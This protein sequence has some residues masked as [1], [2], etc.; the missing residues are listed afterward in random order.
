[1]SRLRPFTWLMPYDVYER[2]KVVSS[3]LQ[4]VLPLKESPFILDVG[5]RIDLLEQ[6]LP[7]RVLS[8]NPDGTGAVYASGTALPFADDSFTAVVNIDTL[9]HLPPDIRLP[10]V[11]ECLRVARRYIIIAAPY[12]SPKH[13]QHEKNLHTLYKNTHGHPHKYLSEHIRYELPSPTWLKELET[14]VVPASVQHFYAGDFIWQGKTF[15]QSIKAAQSPLLQA[16][17]I[18]LKNRITSLA[19]L[20]PIHLTRT[21]TETTNRFYLLVQKQYDIKPG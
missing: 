5:G 21:P 16:K 17:W 8:V 3:L 9:E 14:A 18:N 20:H 2:H 7:Y 4:S 19:L 10:F 1:M 11:R 6:F 15:A 12:G 13:I